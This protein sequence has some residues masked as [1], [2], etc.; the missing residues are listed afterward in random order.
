MKVRKENCLLLRER[1]LFLWG[2]EAHDCCGEKLCNAFFLDLFF[3]FLFTLRVPLL[4]HFSLLITLYN[5]HHLLR[6]GTTHT[7][8]EKKSKNTL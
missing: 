2:G 4:D 8:K 5:R 1:L 6:Y 7:K 3:L